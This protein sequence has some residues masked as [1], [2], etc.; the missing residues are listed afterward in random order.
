MSGDLFTNQKRGIEYGVVARSRRRFGTGFAL[1]LGVAL[2][3]NVLPYIFTYRAYNGDG[4][5]RMGYPFAFR[6]QGG[7]AYRRC[8]SHPALTPDIAIGLAAALATG[9]AWNWL[10]IAVWKQRPSDLPSITNMPPQ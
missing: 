5:E 10:R 1:G 3:A 7:V 6:E 9:V 8:F 4:Y 2:A